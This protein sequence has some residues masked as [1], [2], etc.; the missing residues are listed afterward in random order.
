MT[1]SK[2][3]R[4]LTSSD[5]THIYADA[6]GDHSKQCLLFIHGVTLSGVVF[7][8]VFSNETYTAEFYMVSI[9]NIV[10]SSVYSY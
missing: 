6:V 2:T 5:G 10:D 1:D 4:I 9:A 8:N 3:V 7:D